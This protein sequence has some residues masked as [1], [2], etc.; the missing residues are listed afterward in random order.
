MRGR[1]KRLHKY[2]TRQPSQM[3][4]EIVSA[5]HV[6]FTSWI[7]WLFILI[8]C[9]KFKTWPRAHTR[10]LDVC[11]SAR[12]HFISWYANRNRQ[13]NK[14]KSISATCYKDHKTITDLSLTFS[15][16]GQISSH[17][18]L[19]IVSLLDQNIWLEWN[20]SEAMFTTKQSIQ[21]SNSFTHSP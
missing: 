21:L 6:M 20:P 19:T 12:S 17:R 2:I 11:V 1:Q 18:F 4:A 3:S 9:W 15:G 8:S 5:M 7:H 10:Y 16:P 13:T 14:C